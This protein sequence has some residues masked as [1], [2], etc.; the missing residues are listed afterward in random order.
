MAGTEAKIGF[1]EFR[2]APNQQS[3]P[4]QQDQRQGKFNGNDKT[5]EAMP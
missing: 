2:K 4:D 3:G 5:L 1:Q